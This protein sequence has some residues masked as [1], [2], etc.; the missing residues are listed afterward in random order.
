MN[1]ARPVY[2]QLG[3]DK[4]AR[5]RRS[6]L[7]DVRTRCL[8]VRFHAMFHRSTLF[9]IVNKRL[10]CRY[11][12]FILSLHQRLRRK[13]WLEKVP[14]LTF[15]EA[16]SEIAFKLKHSQRTIINTPGQ[17][18]VTYPCAFLHRKIQPHL[19]PYCLR[20]YTESHPGNGV[21]SLYG[22][23]LTRE[24]CATNR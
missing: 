5:V 14:F 7:I 17:N 22:R 3:L 16:V 18:P 6:N 8:R 9:N 12:R 24:M 15:F 20:W 10:V 23:F 1:V 13:L 2:G 19:Q 21:P 11:F 4:Y